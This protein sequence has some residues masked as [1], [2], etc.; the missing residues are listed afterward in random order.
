ML[1]E[2]YAT[3]TDNPLAVKVASGKGTLEECYAYA[4]EHGEPTHIS[5]KQELYERV[6][7]HGCDDRTD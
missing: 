5:A 4:M 3:W 1:K 2:R 6:F 7:N